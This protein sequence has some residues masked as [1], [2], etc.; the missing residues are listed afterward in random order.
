MNN[1]N[2]FLPQGS[3]LEQK[4]KARTRVKIAVYFSI[5]LSVVAL[6]ALL[7]QGC[8]K[9][10]DSA[11]SSNPDTNTVAAL[12]T[13]PDTN[14]AVTPAPETNVT[15]PAPAPVV[16]P[17]PV[18]EPTPPPTT[19]DYTVIKGDVLATIAKKSNVSLKALLEANPGVDPKKL[20][21]GQKLHLPQ[22][23]AAPTAMAPASTSAADNSSTGGE[24]TYKV[25]S[26]DT[27]TGI[28]K[29]FHVTIKA[30]EAANGMT[31][32]SIKV[33]KT[34]KIPTSASAAPAPAPAPVE[35]TP[36]PMAPAPTSSAPATPPAT[37]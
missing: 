8:R 23:A 36:T 26:G 20:K 16:T 29:H 11:D 22:A 25:K 34:L 7:I 33:G 28:A 18:V 5:S 13:T 37:H 32:T 2:P 17:A 1:P 15:T 31:T 24:Q 35:P 27:L 6:M 12:P 3:F 4:N 9:P 19:E 30:I 21:V 14:V 10:N